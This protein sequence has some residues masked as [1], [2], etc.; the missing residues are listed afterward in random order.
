MS[1]ARDAARALPA[2]LRAGF[3]SAVAYRSEFLI[4]ILS[5]NMPLVMLALWSAVARDAPVGRFGESRFRAYFLAALI[6]RL[7]TG[8][9][10]LW[11][12]NYEVRQGTLGMRLLRPV[13]PFVSYA[14]D[15]LAA[16]CQRSYAAALRVPAARQL[17][18]IGFGTSKA[19]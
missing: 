9:W 6:V 13:H 14:A 10:V 2:M 11:E 1:A 19:A 5:T 17:A 18:R 3:A 12:M 7:L 15:N 8:S 4:W 16:L